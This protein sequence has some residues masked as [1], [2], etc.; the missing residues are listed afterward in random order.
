VFARLVR[1]F[2]C[3]HGTECW[4]TRQRRLS[5]ADRRRTQVS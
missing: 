2:N 4:K 5:S 1:T 3:R